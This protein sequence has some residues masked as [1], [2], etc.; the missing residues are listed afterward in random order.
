MTIVT[1]FGQSVRQLFDLF[2][3]L[4]DLL[5]ERQQF[6]HLGFERRIFFSQRN[7]SGLLAASGGS[8]IYVRCG[9]PEVVRNQEETRS[10]VRAGLARSPLAPAFPDAGQDILRIE[11]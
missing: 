3:Q 5:F 6:C 2:L 10:A 11:L 9:L 7:Y 4:F 1:V 8:P